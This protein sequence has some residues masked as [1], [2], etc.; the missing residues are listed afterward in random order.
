MPVPVPVGVPVPVPV[1]LPVPL[2]RGWVVV[3]EV[4]DVLG[5][6]ARPPEPEPLP[7]PDPL[8]EPLEGLDEEE[9]TRGVNGSMATAAARMVAAGGGLAARGWV[10]AGGV[11]WAGTVTRVGGTWLPTTA[12]ATMARA[13]APPAP[14]TSMNGPCDRFRR[15]PGERGSEGVADV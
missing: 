11:G 2:E 12:M 7:E 8:P 15:R 1:A 3:G 14:A 13:T 4:V 5:E 10:L 9:E 6:V